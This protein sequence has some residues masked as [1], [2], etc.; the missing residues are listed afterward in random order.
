MQRQVGDKYQLLLYTANIT[1]FYDKQEPGGP[2]CDKATE[3]QR[4]N[5]QN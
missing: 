1:D 3:K 5:H 4:P 2:N